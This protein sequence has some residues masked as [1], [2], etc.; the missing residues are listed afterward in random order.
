ME[1]KKV[2]IL[3]ISVISQILKLNFFVNS[4]DTRSNRN[5]DNTWSYNRNGLGTNTMHINDRNHREM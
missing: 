1:D 4:L 5:D 3:R 2:L